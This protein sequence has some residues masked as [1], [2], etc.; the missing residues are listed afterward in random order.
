MIKGYD[1]FAAPRKII[2]VNITVPD[3]NPE[4]NQLSQRSN[5]CRN[6]DIIFDNNPRKI[7]TIKMVFPIIILTIYFVI[8]C[9]MVWFILLV[10]PSVTAPWCNWC[11]TYVSMLPVVTIQP[12]PPGVATPLGCN[13]TTM[14]NSTA[15]CNYTTW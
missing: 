7:D 3:P 2:I 13:Y 14:C 4:G 6:D 12:T 8:Y 11:N 1:G 9:H 10:I 5:Q 15:R